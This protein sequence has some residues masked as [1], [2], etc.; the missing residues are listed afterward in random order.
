V[1]GLLSNTILQ[2]SL[3]IDEERF[4]QLYP[5]VSGYNYFLIDAPAGKTADVERALESRLND[6]GFDVRDARAVLT[7]L[8]AVQNT[9]LSTFQSLGALG[10]LLGVFGLATVQLRSVLE[11]RGELALMRATGFRR[12]RLA[13]MVMLENAVLLLGGLRSV[14]SRRRPPWPRMSW[15]AA[16]TCRSSNWRGCSR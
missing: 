4:K 15:W 5:E 14:C 11:R 7:D 8:L 6:Q 13:E 10:L 2:G 3:F 9:Y 1:A 12:N 16:P